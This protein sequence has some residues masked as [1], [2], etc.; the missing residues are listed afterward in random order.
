M[1][2]NDKITNS[3]FPNNSQNNPLERTVRILPH[4]NDTG[5]FYIALFRKKSNKVLIHIIL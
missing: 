5:G 1:K 2:R 3:M 4:Q